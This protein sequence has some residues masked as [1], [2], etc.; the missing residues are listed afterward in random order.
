MDDR[1]P[2]LGN[3]ALVTK[4]YLNY[5]LVSGFTKDHVKHCNACCDSHDSEYNRDY[6]YIPMTVMNNSRIHIGRSVNPAVKDFS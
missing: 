1:L 3:I 6:G 5:C 4:G 2:Q